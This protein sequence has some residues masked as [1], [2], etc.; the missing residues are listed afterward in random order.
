[1][2]YEKLKKTKFFENYEKSLKGELILK[3]EPVK[4]KHEIYSCGSCGKILV[5]RKENKYILD[6]ELKGSFLKEIRI[7]C[8]CGKVNIFKRG[9]K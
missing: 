7:K 6:D 5:E 3:S 1:M 9:V 2:N 8:I 4:S